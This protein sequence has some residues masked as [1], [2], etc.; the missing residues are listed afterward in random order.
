M[1]Y[2][3]YNYLFI[4]STGKY[5]LYNSETNSFAE[6]DKGLYKQL[7]KMKD[8]GVLEDVD[9]E[10]VVALK[11]A[12]I[13]LSQNND[14]I[15]LDK[16]LKYYLN[17]FQPTALG[18]AL[19]PTTACNFKCPY[20][21]EENRLHKYMSEENENDFVRFIKSH[22]LV[23]DVSLTW[24]GGEP[25]LGFKTIKSILS[26]LKKNNINL[27]S[28]SMISNGY[29]LNEEKAKYFSE[30]PLTF[31]QITIDGNKE[32]HDKRRILL[33]NKPTY[34]K[35]LSNIDYFVHLNPNTNIAIRV[36]IDKSNKDSFYPLYKEL[37]DR[38][39]DFPTINIYPAFVIE[40]T[41]SCSSECSALNQSDRIDFYFELYK[42]HGVNINFYP[43][44]KVGGCGATKV[45]YYV[46]GPEGELYKCW[47]D[48]GVKEKVIGYL[49]GNEIPNYN[50]FCQYLVGP[51][52]FEDSKC[53]KC[54]IFPICDGGCKWI[55]LRNENEGKNF[56]LCSNRKDNLDKF[57]ELHYNQRKSNNQF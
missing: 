7:A 35:I 18:F 24:Y 56:D 51:T 14:T 38:W 53:Q 32:S 30:N 16:K 45:N 3:Q 49:K 19:A 28:H 44:T 13:V 37:S 9:Q 25:L 22:P 21:F 6:L 48:I 42:K 36:N 26:K 23:T 33:N 4:S 12:K 15:F 8:T 54:N 27:A 40:Y 20:C 34:D 50:I 5:L 46:V 43:E 39:R 17:T 55:R 10:T 52:M 11:K 2:S 41:D 57:L 29:L 1:H 47:N 31:I